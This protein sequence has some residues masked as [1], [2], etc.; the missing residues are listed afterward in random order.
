MFS[1]SELRNMMGR[2]KEEAQLV[3][4]T[5]LITRLRPEDRELMETIENNP[6][7]ALFMIGALEGLLVAAAPVVCSAATTTTS[8]I[9]QG[10]SAAYGAAGSAAASAGSAIK[11]SASTVA[12]GIGYGASTVAGGI[13][14]GASAIGS[15]IVGGI[16]S[17]ATYIGEK[18]S[19]MVGNI[20]SL[21]FGSK[22][23]ASTQVMDVTAGVAT[24]AI[25]ATTASNKAAN[26][27]P[28]TKEQI[29]DAILNAM[30]SSPEVRTAVK[31]FVEEQIDR[32]S[33]G[34]VKNL[35]AKF[36]TPL[37]RRGG[38]Q[39]GGNGANGGAGGASGKVRKG[40]RRSRRAKK[41]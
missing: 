40:G 21:F 31:A 10:A 25:E 4:V 27:P 38:K 11:Q 15:G 20:S 5:R 7:L 26:K 19:T 30:H 24:A 34:T 2:S 14:S 12:G 13:A 3:K 9:K 29:R 39:P 18:C 16:G 22:S 8:A 33:Q 35:V 37:K 6:E 32:S 28:P 17:G 41:Y 1:R 36:G 23:P